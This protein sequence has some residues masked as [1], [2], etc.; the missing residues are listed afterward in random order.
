MGQE[1][2]Y[3]NPPPGKLSRI[4]RL[5]SSIVNPVVAGIFIAAITAYK[6][7]SDPWETT[8]WFTFMV[9]LTLIPPLSYI[10]YLVRTGYLVDIYMPD[11][12][13]RV[14]PIAF[15]V[16]WI[17]I[18]DVFLSLIGAPEAIGIILIISII[19]I[20]SLLSVTL[21]WKISFHTG[22]LTTAAAVT[23]FFDAPYAWFVALL[24]PIVGWSR[25]RLRRHTTMQVVGGCVAGCLVAILADNMLQIYLGL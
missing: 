10:I 24:V 6:A 17:L 11:R 20:G 12:Q 15:I 23:I 25:V 5:I 1:A 3:L 9:L 21:L 4:A 19:L 14:K 7:I 18:S 2:S 16:V 13:R 8:I 22:I